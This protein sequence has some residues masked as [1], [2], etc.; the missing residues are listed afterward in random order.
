MTTA[1]SWLQQV[2][3]EARTLK[4]G[5]I[6]TVF[7]FHNARIIRWFFLNFFYLRFHQFSSSNNALFFFYITR[8]L[9]EIMISLLNRPIKH[10]FIHLEMTASCGL[11]LRCSSISRTRSLTAGCSSSFSYALDSVLESTQTQHF[12][13]TSAEDWSSYFF[14]KSLPFR[15]DV[16]NN[17]W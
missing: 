12:G 11:S 1:I 14:G 3:Q 8:F 2:S 13:S 9:E 16:S 4:R 15:K 7:Y 5:Y 17:V 6:K 10:S